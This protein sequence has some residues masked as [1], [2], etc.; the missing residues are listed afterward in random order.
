MLPLC[1]CLCHFVWEEGMG[2]EVEERDRQINA[3]VYV[4]VGR[5]DI[6]L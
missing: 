3:C 2:G 4:N 6:K 5:I 1:F